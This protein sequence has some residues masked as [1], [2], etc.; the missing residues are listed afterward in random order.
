MEVCWGDK[1]FIEEG[2]RLEK[3]KNVVVKIF[4][5]IEEFIRFRLL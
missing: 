2:V 1:G 4:E 3:V 5:E